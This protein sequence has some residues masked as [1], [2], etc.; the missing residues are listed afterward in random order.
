MCDIRK[1]NVYSA[2]NKYA[3]RHL[4]RS[5]FL[6]WLKRELPQQREVLTDR[7]EERLETGPSWLLPLVRVLGGRTKE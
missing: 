3:L 7:W 4:M 2:D 6:L 5:Q 1:Q